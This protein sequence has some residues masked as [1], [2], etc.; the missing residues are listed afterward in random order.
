VAVAEGVGGA[1]PA[2]G[3]AKK[4]REATLK[5]SPGVKLAYCFGQ[6]VE[7]GYLTA[8]TFIFFYY[9]AV[10]GLS[11]SLVGA[12]VAI[13]MVIDAALD[14]IIGS[15]SDSVR[16]KLGRRLP[17]MLVG[18][19]LTF[20]TMGL[21]FMPPP[22]L[23]PLLLF[24]WL[25]IMKMGVRG[26]ASMFN[27]PFFALGG[28]MTDGYTERTRIVAYRLLAGII[29]SVTITAFAYSVFFAGEG[30]LQRPDRYPAFG[31]TIATLV[32]VGALI[33]CAGLWRYAAALPQPLT[34]MKG[35]FRRLPGE[36][37]EIF[38]NRSFLLI[39]LSLFL[40]ASAYGVH[41]SL[42]NHIYVF[43]WKLRPETIQILAYTGLFGIFVATPL[44]PLLMTWIEKKSAGILSFLLMM[45][46]FTVL[47]GLRAAGIYTPTGDAALPAMIATAFTVGVGFGMMA[48]SYPAMMADAADEHEHLFGSRREGLY[49]SGLGFG[50]KAAGGM[51]TLVAGLA[52]DFLHFPRELG[53]TVNAVIDEPVLAGLV[54]AWGIVPALLL[55]LGAVVF[56]PYR[57][58]RARQSE[59]AD[60]LKVKRAEDVTAGRSS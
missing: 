50:G 7:S 22:G 54:I 42:N 41:A 46:G 52:L 20:L 1:I 12:A 18:A 48:V 17:V 40:L 11:G 32:I 55:L 24:G 59:I 30:G 38:R 19:P 39:F 43:V 29:T 13:S 28:E 21:L 6:V 60:A 10:L 37:A 35:M 47:P 15:W 31:W 5:P 36:L 51:G 56:W 27:I 53:R 2:A 45:L 16:S 49:F 26:F 34:P 33:C 44:T 25:T 4:A 3:G 23:S 9:T 14:P 8:N 57:I 58:S